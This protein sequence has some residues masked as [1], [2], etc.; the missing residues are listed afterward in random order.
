MAL[1]AAAGQSQVLDGHEAG[2]EAA[3]KAFDR[4]GHGPATFGIVIAS[5]D[6]P[7]TEVVSGVPVT[8]NAMV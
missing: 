3:R 5:Q 6:Y 7:I 1:L 4:L 8:A 2:S